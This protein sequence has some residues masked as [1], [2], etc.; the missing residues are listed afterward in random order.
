MNA[1][2]NSDCGSPDDYPSQIRVNR[3]AGESSPYLLQHA[4]NPVDWFPWSDEALRR[5][6]QDD[7]PIFLS[8]GYSACHWCHVMER[9]SF[10]DEEVADILNRHFVAIKVDREEHP[11]LDEIYMAAVQ[12]LTGRGGW[13]LSV[14]LT[15]ELAPFFG[16]TYFPLE[17]H[18]GLPGFKTV[19][20][21]V[22][23]LW[24]KQP[25]RVARNAD[26]IVHALES[27]LMRPARG[28]PLDSSLLTRAAEEL[29]AQF[30][31][32]WGGFGGPPKFPDSG[33]IALLLRQYLHT[34]D[35]R[36]LEMV[37]VTLDQMAYGGIHDQIGGGFHRYAVDRH[38][39]TPHFEKMLYDNALLANAYLE[40]WQI[41]GKG[42]YR[43]V[44]ADICD[45]V[46]RDMRDPQGG[47]HSS[48]DA[49]SEGIEGKYYLWRP[50]EIESLLG[51]EDGR[52]V[53]EYY[54][55]SDEG[56]HEGGGILHVP[57]DPA[58]FA[59]RHNLSEQHLLERLTLLRRRLLVERGR[60]VPPG[61]D[62]KVLAAWNGMMISALARGY[63]VFG[64]KP[65]L[66][67]AERAADFIL[68]EMICDGMLLR[69][70]RNRSNGGVA[71]KL[72]AYLDDYAEVSCALIDLF[73]AG[74]DGRWLATADQLA[75]KMLADFWDEQHDG[76]YL[77]SA[78]HRNLLVRTKPVYDGPVPS[79][80]ATAALVLLRLSRLLDNSDYL[81][82][83]E[84]LLASTVAGLHDQ[85]RA[86]LRV[87]CA[88]DFHLSTPLEI[89]IVGRRDDN[90]TRSLL[91]VVHR[92]FIPNRTLALVDPDADSGPLE[93]AIP[94]VAGKTKRSGKATAYV[95]KN[96]AC[97]PPVMDVDMLE[98]TL[99]D[100][101]KR[102]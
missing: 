53:C 85:P 18:P 87:L 88:I 37:T 30:D 1:S 27:V 25:A 81:G 90:D 5:A 56:N 4:H 48:Q 94:F 32:T 10:E 29:R 49:D 75:R 34:G 20:R 21:A 79:G 38:W 11:E 14:F 68:N 96:L 31:P 47:F 39:M 35:G 67:A 3:L 95:C 41:T 73:E 78:A 58:G 64:K 57:S 74:F 71:N 76:F 36:L 99:E 59:R 13:P 92:K 60:R 69:I 84:R 54:G 50:D 42:L 52:L 22:A 51:K 100:A 101:L 15:P 72:P 89:A 33:A 91:D 55:V 66:Q 61:K 80:N 70:Y 23:D 24:R 6:K 102:K 26:D 9:D 82:K 97:M 16:G 83:A 77:T 63:Q 8:I 45:Y 7:K 65:Y 62:D 17:D 40:A 86:H 46:L 2:T 19:L 44:A 12:M 98:Q 43:R 28:G 93:P